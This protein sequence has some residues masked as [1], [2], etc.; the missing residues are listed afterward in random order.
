MD[1]TAASPEL[2]SGW[3]AAHTA[4]GTYTVTHN[5]GLSTYQL[6]TVVT[7]I[8]TAGYTFDVGCSGNQFV[9]YSY[10]AAGTLTDA[11]FFFMSHKLV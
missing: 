6:H 10:N 4:T 1:G 7:G 5:F 11:A 8:G 9:V 2:P 3:S